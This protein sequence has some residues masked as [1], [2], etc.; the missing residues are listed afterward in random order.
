[1]EIPETVNRC[2][3]CGLQIDY[4][5][6]RP[7][8]QE[9]LPTYVEQDYPP[10]DGEPSGYPG[11]AWPPGY[12]G[13]A[14]PEH[15][16]P[17]TLPIP[18]EEYGY[19]YSGGWEMPP[20]KSAPGAARKLW[21]S[22]TA[23]VSVTLAVGLLVAGGILGYR[24]INRPSSPLQQANA[25]LEKYFNAVE[26]GDAATV[27]SLHAPDM[28]PDPA[29]LAEISA[30][31]GMPGKKFSSILLIKLSETPGEMEVEISD[32]V[33]S[34]DLLGKEQKTQI[35]K[36]TRSSSGRAMVSRVKLR[37]VNGTWLIN[38]REIAQPFEITSL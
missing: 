9:D 37:N 16:P 17:G 8:S 22:A 21:R 33:M 24:A 32:A 12:P 10:L 14:G 4:A 19:D 25:L 11:E 5:R 35:S 34:Y 36:L 26:S 38:Q 18:Q 23:L 30:R 1:M 3:N 7:G 15:L 6:N 31:A 2:P 29:A 27:A 28:Q 13:D 20:D